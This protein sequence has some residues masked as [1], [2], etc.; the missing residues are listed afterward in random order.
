PSQDGIARAIAAGG[1]HVVHGA[2]G[3][4]KTHLAIAATVAEAERGGRPILLV[5]TRSGAA[6]IRDEVT[7]RIGRTLD[8]AVVR[9]PAALAFAILRLRASHAGE[10]APTLI[11]GPEQDQVLAD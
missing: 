5:P 2:P 4:G 10:P 11:S 3:S 9:T 8:S 7:R 6:T 1:R